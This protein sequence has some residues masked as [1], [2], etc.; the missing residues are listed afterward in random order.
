MQ[1]TRFPFVQICGHQTAPT[2][3]CST[4]HMGRHPAASLPVAALLQRTEATLAQY[5]ASALTTALVTMQLTS[6]GIIFDHACR[7]IIDTGAIDVTVL[8]SI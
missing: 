1:A 3:V 6:G 2:L 8:I 7:Q 4:K 5:L